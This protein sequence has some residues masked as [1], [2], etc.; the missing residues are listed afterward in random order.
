MSDTPS[1]LERGLPPLTRTDH[2]LAVAHALLAG[3]LAPKSIAIYARDVRAYLRF[4]QTPAAALDA[5]TLARWRAH[6]AANTSLSPHTINRMLAAVKRLVKEAAIQ[7]Q[8]DQG[9]AKAFAQ[10][11]GVKVAA[12][13]ERTK[14][15]ARTRIT[16]AAMRRLCDAPNPTTLKGLRDR[17][18]LATLA[19]S[20]LRVDEL[21]SLTIGQ[22]VAQDG[23]YL[24]RV[25]GKNDTEHREAPL[26]REAHALITQWL[27]LRPIG[28]DAIFTSF[29]GR[30]GRASA[31]PMSAVSVWRTVQHYAAEVGL[32]NIKPHDFRRFV[33]TQLA[34]GDIR[35]AQKA[36]GHKRIDTTARHYVLDE[37]E[38]GLTDELY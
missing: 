23:G 7:G 30:G 24:V 1:T 38:V 20:A 32:A 5:A 9:I 2:T 27:A 19:S 18:L 36:L 15:T 25:R 10:I 35:R 37:L 28:S 31:A 33:G 14:P 21:A 11:G 8:L 29:G 6:L 12:L 13:K 16:P 4:A 22:I 26:S 17:A 34:K 3:Q